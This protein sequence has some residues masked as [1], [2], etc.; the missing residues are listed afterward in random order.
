[1]KKPT[2]LMLLSGIAIFAST[3]LM[4]NIVIEKAFS[5]EYL[6]RALEAGLAGGTATWLL[7]LRR[8]KKL[9][10]SMT[11]SRNDI[12]PGAPIASE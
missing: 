10:Q 3:Y 8:W 1:M 12:Q 6:V 9:H 11:T 2:C 4:T 5:T 7:A